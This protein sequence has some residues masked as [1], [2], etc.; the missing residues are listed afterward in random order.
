MA[1][2][3]DTSVT[4]PDIARTLTHPQIAALAQVDLRTIQRWA[5]QDRIPGK[6]TLPGRSVRYD[7]A[8]IEAWLAARK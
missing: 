8:A 7:R 2:P 6:L 4:I 3:K 5:A 1:E